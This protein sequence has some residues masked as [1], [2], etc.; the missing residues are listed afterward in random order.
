MQPLYRFEQARVV[1]SLDC[2]CLSA[3][4]GGSRYA[5]DFMSGRDLTG[6]RREM[7]RLYVAETTVTGTGAAADHRLPQKPSDLILL[8]RALA[9]KLGVDAG[10]SDDAERNLSP[11]ARTWVSA[12]AADLDA[13]RGRGV[14][15]VGDRQPWQLHWLAY[16][17][18]ETLGNVGSVVRYIEPIDGPAADNAASLAELAADMEADRVGVLLIVGGNPVYNAPVDLAFADKLKKPNVF[19]AHLSPYFDET[20]TICRWHVPEAHYLEAWGDARA[21]DGTASLVQ[22]L[23]APLFSGKTADEFLFAAT[24]QPAKSAYDLVRETWQARRADGFAE[25]WQSVLREGV[26]PDTA[27]QPVTVAA[28]APAAEIWNEKNVAAGSSDGSLEVVLA[29]DPTVG[30]GTFYGN[31]WL[32]ELPKTW[33][34]LTWSN[35][36]LLAPATAERLKIKNQ[37]IVEVQHGKLSVSGPAWIAPGHP[38]DTATLH[39]GYGR[40]LGQAWGEPHGFDAYRLRTRET[41]SGLLRGVTLTST[42]RTRKLAC[43]QDHDTMAGRDIVRTLT[44]DD[45]LKRVEKSTS[46]KADAHGADAHGA[47]GGHHG[48]P[49]LY[50]D[51]EYK[52]PAWGM[53]I[54]LSRCLDCGSCVVA[55]QAENN[56]PVVGETQVANGREMHWLRIDRYFHGDDPNNPEVLLEP[57]SCQHCEHAPCEVVCPVAATTHSSEGLNEMTYNRCVGT[58]YCSNNCPYKVRRFN[59]L[60][61]NNPTSP[62]ASMQ[63]NPD[64]TVRSRGVMEKCTYCVQRINAARINASIEAAHTGEPLKIP[65]GTIVTACQ[66]AC[67]SQAIVFGDINDPNSRVSRIKA[68]PR[69][70]GV[71]EELGTRPRT[72]YLAHVS[73]PSPAFPKPAASGSSPTTD[74]AH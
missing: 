4:E 29:P 21:F 66:S 23:I 71:L 52:G 7:N 54:D 68:D 49:T 38:L 58:R 5:R 50:P 64:V 1:V 18:N 16:R 60:E 31:A 61:F 70:Y 37:D 30:D 53:A 14:V 47:H 56:I 32:Q 69:N 10:L 13:A 55:C 20:S 15:V 12:A 43:T 65:D 9:A 6:D 72:T 27:A 41:A 17:L 67:P 19:T 36:V 33:T 2:D 51:W 3:L 44:F 35:A 25:F 40:R 73:N 39:L 42:G 24:G 45:F 57:M 74:H 59:F 62:L 34:R 28:A 26:I 22:P 8:A 63:P 11:A 46:P 48:H